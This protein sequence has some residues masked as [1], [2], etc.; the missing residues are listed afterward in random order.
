MNTYYI[1]RHGKTQWNQ[2]KK[3]QGK[4][5]SPL[6]EEGIANAKILANR[7]KDLAIDKVVS[8]NLKRAVDTAHILMPDKEILLNP[9]FREIDFGCWE[10][11]TIDEIKKK[12]G[13]LYEAW[14]ESPENVDFHGGESM[15]DAYKRVQSTFWEL[16]KKEQNQNIL[17]VAHGI[18][19]KLLL[20]SFLDVPLAKAFQL[21]Q[22]NLSLNIIKTKNGVA[23][24]YTM[25]DTAHLGVVEEK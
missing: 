13:S 1:V 12:H 21:I 18:I 14:R 16:D 20:I 24:I 25:N 8:S 19:I 9:G 10:G 5:D 15:I 6:T 23:D 22:T 17:I 2:M 7:L 3:T 4:M 11:L